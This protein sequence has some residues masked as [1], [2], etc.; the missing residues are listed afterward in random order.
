MIGAEKLVRIS[1]PVLFVPRVNESSDDKTPKYGANFLLPLDYPVDEIQTRIVNAA[2]ARWGKEAIELLKEKEIKTP[3]KNQARMS[4]HQG[5]GE[6]Y[7]ITTSSRDRPG[8]VDA[9]V[10]PIM[11]P[12]EVW[13]GLLCRCTVNVYTYDHPKGGKGVGFGLQNVMIVKDDGTRWD[14]R[15]KAEDDFAQ[16][17]SAASSGAAVS[18]V[19]GIFD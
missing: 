6:G 14:N 11:D 8:V 2:V 13:G 9:N 19:S 4:K 12:S 3:L 7:Y 16:Y 15:A 1:F 18:D 5:Y 10:Q 17:K